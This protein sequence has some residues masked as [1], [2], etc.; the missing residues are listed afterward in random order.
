MVEVSSVGTSRKQSLMLKRPLQTKIITWVQQQAADYETTT[1]FI[2]NFIKK[3]FNHGNDI[4]TALRDLSPLEQDNWKVSMK[5][6]ESNDSYTRDQ[7]NKQYEM[8]F[9][10]DYEEYKRRVNHHNNNH[11]KAYAM[12]W[13]RCR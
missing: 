11:I 1:E 3:S 10:L 4:C 12:I 6:S 9:C 8:E 7:E 5:F 13:E 2:V